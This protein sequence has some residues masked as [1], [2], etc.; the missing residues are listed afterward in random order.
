VGTPACGGGSD[1]ETTAGPAT[2]TVVPDDGCFEGHPYRVNGQGVLKACSSG[3][4]SLSVTNISDSVVEASLVEPQSPFRATFS[5]APGSSA[6]VL[7]PGELVS[8]G[9]DGS[10]CTLRPGDSAAFFNYPSATVAVHILAR[11]TLT[12]DVAR[13]LGGYVDNATN[14]ALAKNKAVG[15]AEQLSD[16]KNPEAFPEDEIRG[17]LGAAGP[18]TSAYKAIVQEGRESSF[19][20]D[21]VLKSLE[22]EVRA[23]WLDELLHGIAQVHPR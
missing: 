2:T 10:S 3:R 13:I 18:C 20:A 12:A 15:C 23:N 17:I 9:C 21:D 8:G 4:L 1:D 7:L 5:P 11:E 19:G 14:P 6:S 22:R 16:L